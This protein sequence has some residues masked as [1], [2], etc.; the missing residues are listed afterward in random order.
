M[1]TVNDVRGII[2]AMDRKMLEHHSGQ[3]QRHAVQGASLVAE[4]RERV[5]KL[6]LLGADCVHAK[7]LLA[8]FE[9]LQ[10]MHA[11]DAERIR[12]KMSA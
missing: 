1:T 11:D 8:L 4:Q 12:R 10:A 9:E 5:M 2:A 3:A 6:E 7:R